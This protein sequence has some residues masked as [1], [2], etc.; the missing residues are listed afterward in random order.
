MQSN[1]TWL[2]IEGLVSYLKMSRIK[3]YQMAQKG[4]LP[5]SKIGNQW[6]FNRKK[7]DNWMNE[8]I[9]YKQKAGVHNV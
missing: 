6:R 1:D 9:P 8:D 3:L 2:T 5:A 4:K 7:I